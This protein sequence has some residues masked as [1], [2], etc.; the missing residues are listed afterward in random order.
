MSEKITRQDEIQ[1]EE[2][3]E[4]V[5]PECK[6]K[7]IE[8]LGG[9]T[10]RTFKVTFENERPKPLVFRIPGEGTEE[11]I[12]RSLE[13]VYAKLASD[14]EIDAE[15]IHFDNEGHK[16]SEYIK[17][18]TKLDKEKAK[19]QKYLKEISRV[20]RKLHNLD[21]DDNFIF[22]FEDEE[23]KYINVIKKSK[24]F[25]PD[26]LDEISKYVHEIKEKVDGYYCGGLV[27]S[28]NDPLLENWVIGEDK[29]Y[30]IDWE[31]SGKN[32]RFWDLAIISE[33]AHFSDEDD[34]HLLTNYFN[35]TPSE[36]EKESILVY[37]ICQDYLWGLWGY[38]RIKF[39]DDEAFYKNYGDER[40][41]RLYSNLKKYKE[42]YGK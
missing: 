13:E 23:E 28:H 12:T 35:K 25:Y 20:F 19:E 11:I 3:K 5:F 40:I 36:E 18:I 21:L 39:S 15:L 29:I 14:N 8:R 9:L 32:S 10:N 1:I 37:K 26:G 42:R 33:E 16:I 22:D 27:P 38:A 7:K 2:M 4:K 34:I 30:L 24:S 41:D 17:P 31:Y 6:I